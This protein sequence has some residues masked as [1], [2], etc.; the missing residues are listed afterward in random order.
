MSN[1][2]ARPYRVKREC[3]A[4]ARGMLENGRVIGRHSA[5]PDSR[6]VVVDGKVWYVS[7]PSSY[8]VNQGDYADFMADVRA[9][10][11]RYLSTIDGVSVGEG[12]AA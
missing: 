1:L 2:R 7:G 10:N 5:V 11:R 12:G 3:A 9:G 8:P 6:Y 4:N